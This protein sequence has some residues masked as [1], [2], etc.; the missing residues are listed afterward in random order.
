MLAV[1]AGA[2]DCSG[3]CAGCKKDQFQTLDIEVLS[4]VRIEL[5]KQRI[6]EKLQLRER[7]IVKE[8]HFIPHGLF[9]DDK[10]HPTEIDNDI[11]LAR[12]SKYVAFSSR[13]Y[14]CDFGVCFSFDIPVISGHIVSAEIRFL[15]VNNGIYSLV[16]VIGS[17]KRFLGEEESLPDG[18]VTFYLTDSARKWTSTNLKTR[19]FFIKCETCEQI[20]PLMQHPVLVINQ[21]PESEKRREKRRIRNNDCTETT[22][23]CCREQLTISMRDIGWDDWIIHPKEI[24]THFCKGRCQTELAYSTTRRNSVLSVAVTTN[25][26]LLRQF[27]PCC[28]PTRFSN[29]TIIYQDSK[30]VLRESILPDFITE[31]CG[32]VW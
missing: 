3:N 17:K 30:Q 2:M 18:W 32:C 1:C 27:Q 22:S 7:P 16:E 14:S 26:E 25:P 10:M 24:N 9:L 4:E 20:P 28:V 11:L 21:D 6:L 12:T 13:V 29:L 15:A 8:K 23:T 19:H 31:S 5:V